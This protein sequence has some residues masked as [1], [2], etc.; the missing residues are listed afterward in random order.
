MAINITFTNRID[1]KSLKI[2]IYG[3][4]GVGKTVLMKTA[5]NPLIISAENGLLSLAG[6][7]IPVIE[8]KTLQDI[9]EMV[10]YLESD[11]KEIQEIQTICIDS[12]SEIAEIIFAE[13]EKMTSANG[14]VLPMLQAYG[15]LGSIGKNIIRRLLAIDTK[16][17]YVIAKMIKH[18]DDYSNI[19]TW[20]PEMPGGQL[21]NFLPYQ[22]DLVCPLRIW[23]NGS[24]KKQYRYLQ[25]ESDI[26]YMAKD[27]SR[28]LAVKEEANITKLFNK[29]LNK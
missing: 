7:N 12:I 15:K 24:G 8:L 21:K 18:T 20:S 5:P 1:L 22:F 13:C 17:L 3:E 4:P 28:K 23:Q 16:H 27:R 6:E 10:E 25:T 11:N 26:Q 9:E 19:T 2:L 29:I 14:K